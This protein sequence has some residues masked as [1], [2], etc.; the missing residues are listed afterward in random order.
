MSTSYF[1]ERLQ[2]LKDGGT[3][4]GTRMFSH[5]QGGTANATCASSF[6]L[7]IGTVMFDLLVSIVLVVSTR[8]R[9]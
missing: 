7:P 8:S 1:R 5:S 2:V 4:S 3:V 6:E 9:P